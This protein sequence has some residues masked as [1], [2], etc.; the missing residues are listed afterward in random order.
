MKRRSA[1]V[2]AATLSGIAIGLIAFTFIYAKGYSYVTNDPAAC[3]NCHIMQD[4]Y[5]AW[6]RA[7]HR[8]V[9]TCNDCHTP[10]GLIPKYVTKARNGFW[11]SFYFTIGGYPDPLRITDRNRIVTEQACRKCHDELTASIEPVR[12]SSTTPHAD[13]LLCITCHRTVGHLE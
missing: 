8:A 2:M 5:D 11:H 13:G 9:A 12:T 10:P 3:A 1:T 7:S 4:H 6:T